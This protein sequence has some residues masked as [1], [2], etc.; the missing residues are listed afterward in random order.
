MI[1]EE[2]QDIES[3]TDTALNFDKPPWIFTFLWWM[4]DVFVLQT[5]FSV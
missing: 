3:T 4:M 1:Q 5:N 2:E